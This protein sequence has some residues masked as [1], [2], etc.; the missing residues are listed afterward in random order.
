MMQSLAV[1][2]RLRHV[3]CLTLLPC[4]AQAALPM[5]AAAQQY[6][7]LLLPT[8]EIERRLKGQPF[9]VVDWRG[10]RAE[11]DRTQRVLLA[12][13]DDVVMLAKWANAPANGAAFNNEP[14]Y[15]VAAYEVQKLFLDEPE[16]VVPPTLLRSL[17]IAFVQQ[18]IPGARSTFR[19]APGSIIV[20]LQYWLIGVT[21]QNI[22]E[23]Q[24]AMTDDVYARHIGNFNLLTY[25]IQHGDSNVG[26]FLI[27]DAVDDPRVFSVDN[28]V[29]F[30]SPASNRGTEWRD[31]RVKRLPRHTVDRLRGITRQELERTLAVLA[32]YEIHAGQLVPVLPGRNLAPA[33]GVRRS[34]ERVQFGLTTREIR[35]VE[36]R[37]RQLLRQ[38]DAGQV[39]LF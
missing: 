34:R 16:Y 23:P 14:R 3:L 12:F 17:P 22:W 2:R 18:Q 24:R 13:E 35:D 20:A 21:P 8:D 29:A 7:N 25:L 4:A 5:L 27:S 33:R 28:G 30:R 31:L 1:G 11:G 32:E 19:E 38:I 15:E 37:L 9:S 36:D 39:T 26:N 10:S 6:Y